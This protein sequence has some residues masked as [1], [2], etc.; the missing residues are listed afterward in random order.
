MTTETPSARLGWRR[1]LRNAS[2]VAV[3]GVVPALLLIAVM[4]IAL[5]DGYPAWDFHNELYPQAEQ[6]LSG[7]NPYP[8]ADFDPL[9]GTNLVWPPLAAYL[10]AP[11]TLLPTLAADVSFALFGLAC[12]AA[13][14][15]VVGVRDWR[16]YGVAAL[17]P[18]VF[19]EVGLSHLTPIL[20]LLLACAWRTR[21]SD[22]TSGLAVGLAVALKFFVWPMGL[23]LV[24]MGK[25]RGAA[26]AAA[27]AVLSLLLVLPFTSIDL[28]VR[29]LFRVSQA[30]DQD[31]YTL[32]G[33]VAQA[34]GPDVVGRASTLIFAIA[35][36]VA[37]VRFRSFT[38]AV[39]TALVASPI[40]W[41]DYYALA[42]VP[43]AIARPRLSLIWFVPL[44]TLGLEGAGW[45]IGDTLGTLRVLAAFSFVLAV[46]FRAE[47]AVAEDAPHEIG[48]AGLARRLA[49]R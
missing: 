36:A 7:R 28:Y 24:A 34:G 4:R 12:F 44:A 33:L 5:H 48:L 32:F 18:P 1:T 23:W 2:L 17:W 30:Y 13:A 46:A 21:D 40:V 6:M 14:L 43:L 25:L 45:Q 16:V 42:A 39:A 26:V 37:T 8:P 27:L 38:L 35:L 3:F 19:I 49:T 10:V 47:R 29:A 31:S 22:Y 15:F 9:I 11:W 41:L 20:A